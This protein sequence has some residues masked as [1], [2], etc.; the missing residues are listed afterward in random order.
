MARLSTPQCD[1]HNFSDDDLKLVFDS[2]TYD[3][4]AGHVEELVDP[5]VASHVEDI[6]GHLGI[7]VVNHPSGSTDVER[8][9]LVDSTRLKALNRMLKKAVDM[10]AMAE[11]TIRDHG[12]DAHVH[13]D[14]DHRER[15]KEREAHVLELIKAAPKPKAPPET[16]AAKAKA[17]R[18]H[19]VEKPRL[20]GGGSTKGVFTPTD[21]NAMGEFG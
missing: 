8:K 15:F 7:A 2:I 3:F 19:A 1:V 10:Y 20:G 6:Y 16:K 17:A 4:P 11:A 12:R 21:A 5:E 18:G 9:F 14:F 13:P